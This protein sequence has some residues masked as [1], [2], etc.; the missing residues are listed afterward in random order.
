MSNVGT[1]DSIKSFDMYKRLPKD[2]VQPTFSGALSNLD[3]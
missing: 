2:L 1:F 3:S